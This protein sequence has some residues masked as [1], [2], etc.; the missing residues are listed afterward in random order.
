MVVWLDQPVLW[1]SSRVRSPPTGLTEY[2]V[3]LIQTRWRN[4]YTA[5]W[6]YALST[7]YFF[8]AGIALFALSNL[9]S[10]YRSRRNAKAA[11]SPSLFGRGA[12]AVRFFT[13]RQFYVR[14]FGWYTP[15][16]GPLVL[17][18][19]IFVFAM[20]LSF[21]T[22]PYY[23]PASGMGNS[24]PFLFVRTGWISLAI[25][26]FMMAFAPKFNLVGILTGVSHE[27]LQVY[28]RWS[29]W[30]MYITSLL[31]TFPFIVYHIHKK[32]DMQS[33]W[34][35]TSFYWT[36][37]VALIAQTWLVVM[38][39]G[40]IRS[41]YYETFKKLHFIAAGL[42][43]AALFVH[44]G[45]TLTSWDYFLALAVIYGL[46]LFVRL[47]RVAVNGVHIATF[48][49]LPERMVKVS[50][51][52]KLTWHPGQHYFIRFLALGVH[53]FT[54]HP[55]SV[56]SLPSEGLEVYLRVHDGITA[57]LA[58]FALTG[59]SSRVLLDGPYGGLAVPLSRYE[60]VLLI[61]G[62]SGFS[63]VLPVLQDLVRGMGDDTPCKHIEVVWAITQPSS[64]TWFE[65]ALTSVLKTAPSGTV[66]IS[67][68]VTGQLS[69]PGSPVGD[70]ESEVLTIH[71]GRPDL[72]TLVKASCT[73]ESA[74]V[75]IASCG[76]DSM[77]LDVRNAV[78]ECQMNIARG[79]SVCKDIYLHSEAYRSVLFIILSGATC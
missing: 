39:W 43:V 22:H 59:K 1:H 5:D 55:F 53:G 35:T 61:A 74:S 62:G 73:A 7:V 15:P 27:K 67:I 58:T 13:A 34:R 54:S 9:I 76:P 57:R 70:K 20:A 33:E 11:R 17:V 60:K 32:K 10:L 50:I 64:R 44:V 65:D 12:A 46:S 4:W 79:K 42:F 6:D 48:E 23:W 68:Y 51:P 72:V 40:P 14:R 3:A 36:G 69:R 19:G 31:H 78:A 24:P 29:A 16:L 49:T 18:L 25:L 30:V 56:V 52:T 2:Q 41:R 63:F 8:C 45:Y 28:H 75:G 47:G 21:G 38:S 26:P 71:S 66:D 37:I 77:T